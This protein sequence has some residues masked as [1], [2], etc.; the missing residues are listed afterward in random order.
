VPN[1]PIDTRVLV[2]DGPRRMHVERRSSPEPG[3]S[4]VRIRVARAGICGSDLHGYTGESGRRV[5]GMIMGHEA[6]GWIEAVGPGA[7]AVV[8]QPV[9]FNPAIPCPG[10]CG[11]LA[12][13]RCERLRI[14]GV[15]PDVPGA[16]ADRVIVPGARVIPIDGIPVEWAAA[17]EP[18]AVGLQAAHH[19]GISGGERVLVVGGGMIGQCVA[20]AARV[21]GAGQVVISDPVEE[22]RTLAEACGFVAATPESIES[23]GP[24]GLAVDA[25]GLS[26]TAAAA[27]RA[28]SPGGTVVFVGLGAPEMVVPLFDI[29]VK[30]RRILG[31]FCYRDEVFGEA[32]HLVADRSLDVTP[33]IGPVV[34]LEDAPAAFEDLAGGVRREVKILVTTGAEPPT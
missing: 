17:V 11:H 23:L 28:V 6:S 29:V 24:F 14:V 7:S 26:A 5:P 10:T 20:Q 1:E 16:F 3:Q 2:F 15:T 13:N 18:M 12:E 8:G 30:E 9:T 27:I 31:S 21:L 22:R 34:P 33:L 32:A 19:L 25:V 4:E